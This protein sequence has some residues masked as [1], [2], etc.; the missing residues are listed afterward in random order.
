YEPIAWAE[1]L[2]EPARAVGHPRLTY[3]YAVASNCY[4]AGRIDAAIRYTEAAQSAISGAGDH[5]LLPYLA[6]GYLGGA[7]IAVGQPER[8][9]RWCRAQLA[10]GLDSHPYTTASLVMGLLAAGSMDEASAAADG[11]IDAAEATGNPAVLA[12]ALHANGWV[13][14]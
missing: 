3:L 13:L 8:W 14:S 4:M 5:L 2:I 7:Y 6:E 11:L 9:I 12:F 1:E 10:R